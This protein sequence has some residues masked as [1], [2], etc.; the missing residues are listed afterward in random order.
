MKKCIALSLSLLMTAGAGF[1]LVPVAATVD[2]PFDFQAGASVLPA[3][4]YV[5][6]AARAQDNGTVWIRNRETGRQI[7]VM[8]RAG[9]RVG[10]TG[11]NLLVFHQ[12]GDHHVLVEYRNA[13]AGAA[14]KLPVPGCD[15]IDTGAPVQRIAL[16]SDR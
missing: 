10:N 2:I 6:D 7:A 14:R 11:E 4:T 1:G 15:R 3:G 5:V 12:Y 9:G 13:D 8:T 16:R